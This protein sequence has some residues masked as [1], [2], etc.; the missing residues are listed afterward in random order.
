MGN[1]WQW[2]KRYRGIAGVVGVSLVLALVAG[3]GDSNSGGGTPAPATPAAGTVTGQVVS[4]ANNAPVNGATVKTDTGTATTTADGKFSVSAPAGDRT[5]VNVEA[6]GF[7][8]AF[9]IAR[10]T[11]GQTTNLGVKLV[12][13]GVTETVSIAA[14]GTVSVPNSPARVAIPANGLVPAA[15]GT[16]AGSVAVSLTPI[17]PAVDTNLMP[18]GFNGIASGG[19]SVQSL[20]SGGALAFDIRDSAGARYTLAPGRTATIRIPLGTQSANPPTTMPL[21]YFDETEGLWREDGTATLQGTGANRFY[22]GTVARVVYWN[23]D[24]VFDSIVVNGCVKDD[25]GRPVANAWVQTEGV[26][27]TGV[28]Y[29]STAADGT[30]SVAMRRNSRAK[31]GLFEF[32]R[33]T[34]TVA[35]VS[36]TVNV[37][38][39]A[40]DIN[41]SDCLVKQPGPLAITTAALPG[42]N[43]GVAYNQTL[44]ASGGVPGYVWSLNTGSNPLPD[45]LTLNPSGVISGTPG[46]AETKTITLKVAD[47]TG[48]SQTKTFT[49]EILG[50]APPPP[51]PPVS[52]ALAITTT[53]LPGGTVG[54]AYS[55][56]LAVSGGVPGYAWT[57]AEGSN[58]PP[59]GVSLNLSGVIAGTP[60]GA[61]TTT[62]TVKVIDSVGG[63]ATKEFT[64][65]VAAP[66]VQ[67]L[68]I[69]TTVLPAGIVGTAYN[70]TLM[71]TGGTGAKSWSVS[72]GT[73]PAGVSLD[74]STGVI[75]GTPTAAGAAPF[76]V[77]VQDSGT[78]Q[79]AVEL[80]L[81][82]AILSSGGSTGGAGGQLTVSNAPASVGGTFVVT[83][84]VSGGGISVVDGSVVFSFLEASNPFH[85]EALIFAR[86]SLSNIEG[87][88]F[89]SEDSGP[90]NDF[91]WVCSGP[92]GCPGVTLNR[93]AG[94]LTFVNVV[95]TGEVG[96]APPITL[97][98]TLTFTPF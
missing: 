76:T 32:D 11:S 78:L 61:G 69:T 33:Q 74:T 37:G 4:L 41:L 15:G 30:F 35:P 79:Q 38:P 56:T 75:S 9:P 90:E 96:E 95:L 98:G 51:S 52:P 64:I 81:T 65:T 83:P 92:D 43:V 88:A 50:V 17:N 27:Y 6:T 16:P 3:C 68:A 14:G 77:R 24:L 72:S 82:I 26:D 48:A 55:Q 73:L 1:V 12:P 40:T 34:F 18:G 20:E 2:E 53:S 70:T 62:F 23:A 42:G 84:Q 13:I 7:A 5:I 54:V 80:P 25:N 39:S 49:L 22:E 31:L 85:V 91:G 87:V 97:N 86:S 46:T 59:A 58:P 28:A 19:G 45:G 47:S 94:T 66:N 89:Q 36:N 67:T 71:A 57:L 60:R 10:V 29:D 8:E 44:A 63:A 93:S 21:W